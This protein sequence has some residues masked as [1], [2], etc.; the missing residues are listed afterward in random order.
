[1][2]VQPKFQVKVAS[3]M[4]LD[5]IRQNPNSLVISSRF[6]TFLLKKQVVQEK[7]ICFWGPKNLAYL[8]LASKNMT[9]SQVIHTFVPKFN[10][11]S[12]KLTANA[13]EN[14]PLAPNGK[15]RLP[16]TIFRGLW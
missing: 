13:P 15:D 6:Q 2:V 16:T 11:Q 8:L 9:F 5:S 1:M 12:L 10:L 3:S 14:R 7:L 4:I